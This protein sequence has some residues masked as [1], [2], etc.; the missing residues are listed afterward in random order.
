M[1]RSECLSRVENIFSGKFPN[2]IGETLTP[3]LCSRDDLVI[4]R[5]QNPV[6]SSYVSS[7]IGKFPECFP[8]R[9][10]DWILAGLS[11]GR[12]RFCMNGLFFFVVVLVVVYKD[13]SIAA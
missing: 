3:V 5:T 6:F 12:I 7:P 8:W 1:P 10:S 13:Q 4:A 2:P 9:N 11:P